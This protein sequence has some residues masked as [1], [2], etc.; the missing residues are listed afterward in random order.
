M[1]PPHVMANAVV[2]LAG[3]IAKLP[4]PTCAF[5]KSTANALFAAAKRFASASEIGATVAAA[6]ASGVIAEGALVGGVAGGADEGPGVA[7]L[8]SVCFEQPSARA[9]MLAVATKHVTSFFI[10]ASIRRRGERC[11]FFLNKPTLAYR[12]APRNFE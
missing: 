2:M 6:G 9:P 1:A 4:R 11:R 3:D 8:T 5:H 10:A 7:G 12:Q